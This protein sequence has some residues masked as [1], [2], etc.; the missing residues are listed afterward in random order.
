M[1]RPAAA[2]RKRAARSPPASAELAELES[3]AEGL[4]ALAAAAADLGAAPLAARRRREKGGGA[5]PAR[6]GAKT[7]LAAAAGAARRSCGRR[8]E[9]CGQRWRLE[10]AA[11]AASRRSGEAAGRVAAAE[12]AVAAARARLEAAAA[13]ARAAGGLDPEAPCPL[14]GQELGAS[15]DEVQRHR[16]AARQEAE[17]AAEAAAAELGAARSER[18]AAE[19]T[20]RAATAALAPGAA[21]AGAL[22]RAARPRWP[23]P[24]RH[25]MPRKPLWRQ[26]SRV[27]SAPLARPASPGIRT[28]AIAVMMRKRCAAR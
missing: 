16:E 22:G 15:F 20:E 28:V 10:E 21:P 24:E 5:G 26:R 11:A 12:A 4:P 1:P 25:W 3:A 9:P 18:A 23:P 6:H 2:T 17:A 13:E 14:C 7:E 8:P 27:P 19:E